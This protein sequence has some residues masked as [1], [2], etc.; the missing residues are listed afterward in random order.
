MCLILFALNEHPEYKLILAANRDE[1]FNRETL[2]AHHWEENEKI[3]GGK[4][5]VSN[6]TWL[7][8]RV[9]GRFIAITNYRDLSRENKN[10]KSRGFIS[11]N[12]LLGDEKAKTFIAN[13]SNER[14][15]FNG[16]NLLFS[17][18]GCNSLNHY[19]NI[20]NQL[21]IIKSGVHGLSNA[22]LDTPW[23]RGRVAR[24]GVRQDCVHGS[25]SSS[26]GSRCGAARPA[27]R[28]EAWRRD[29]VMVYAAYGRTG[30]CMLQ[31]YCRKLGVRAVEQEL[32]EL[33]SVLGELP[34]QHP[35]ARLLT[36][37]KD[38]RTPAALADALLNPQDRAYTVPQLYEWP[39]LYDV[40]GPVAGPRRAAATSSTE[41]ARRSN[42]AGYRWM[43]QASPISPAMPTAMALLLS[44]TAVRTP[45]L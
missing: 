6:G 42:F 37:A 26:A 1:F 10:A 28:V 21:S 14:K 44:L 19:S 32:E 7:G 38:F 31:D 25:A 16:F 17:A 15:S 24:P 41:T 34:A 29:A 45:V 33:P 40:A 35:L 13:V 36:Q 4:D 30:I 3:I 22:L 27:W 23:L 2:R 39:Q 12:F 43:L 8:L 18:D 5:E 20:S 11:R 9:D